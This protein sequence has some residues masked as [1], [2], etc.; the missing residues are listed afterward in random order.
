MFKTLLLNS[1]ILHSMAQRPDIETLKEENRKYECLY[2]RY[3]K[4]Y[5]DKYK[6]T[7]TWIAVFKNKFGLVSYLIFYNQSKQ[8]KSASLQ[9]NDFFFCHV[10]K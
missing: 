9:K 3:R 5:K 7:N 10:V 4:E 6:K 8:K 2:N 1:S